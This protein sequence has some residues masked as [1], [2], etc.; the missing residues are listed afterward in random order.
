MQLP[1]G[2][3]AL[4]SLTFLGLHHYGFFKV[5]EAV[6]GLLGLR[7]LDLSKNNLAMLQ[8]LS[9][10]S[11]LSALD[12]TN[13]TTLRTMGL[14]PDLGAR[15]PALQALTLDTEVMEKPLPTDLSTVT[16]LEVVHQRPLMFLHEGAWE[17]LHSLQHCNLSYMAINTPQCLALRTGLQVLV[18]RRCVIRGVFAAFQQLAA[19]PHLTHLDLHGAVDEFVI[20]ADMVQ[21]GPLPS[22]ACAHLTHLNLSG[23]DRWLP[24]A[25]LPLLGVLTGLQ[26]LL[27]A[28]ISISDLE[29]LGPWLVQQP[30][31]AYLDLSKNPLLTAHQLQPLPTQLEVLILEGDYDGVSLQHL[32]LSLVQLTGISELHLSSNKDLQQLP[33]W[34]SCLRRLELLD[35]RDTGVK[36][37]QHVL[38]A[39]PALRRVRLSGGE[40][41]RAAVFAGAKH[42]HFAEQVAW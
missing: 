10:L 9:G 26:Q 15:L 31:L 41:L 11:Q 23:C 4:T 25:Q 3:A 29:H 24:V 20:P 18:L 34:L 35:L 40:P 14:P 28:D 22:G 32:P 7:S 37:Q 42:L 16:R 1:E 30:A 5:P 8:Q 2:L 12:I 21:G 6:V 36:T 38:A 33:E 13:N 27:L 19:L 39:L 17:G